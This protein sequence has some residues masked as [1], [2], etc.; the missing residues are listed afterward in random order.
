MIS[1]EFIS[2]E[3]I[4][5]HEKKEVGAVWQSIENPELFYIRI[6]PIRQLFYKNTLDDAMKLFEGNYKITNQQ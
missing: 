6:D 2:D 1:W 4:A 5:F 3:W